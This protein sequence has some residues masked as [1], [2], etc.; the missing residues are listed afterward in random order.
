MKV[1][2]N[3]KTLWTILTGG[4]LS[5]GA[6]PNIVIVVIR[7]DPSFTK[8]IR[9]SNRTIHE[10][11]LDRSYYLRN[12]KEREKISDENRSIRYLDGQSVFG[13]PTSK[14]ILRQWRAT[15]RHPRV[16]RQLERNDPRTAVGRNHPADYSNK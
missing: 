5:I 7:F 16:L 12:C 2:K 4:E 14:T 8:S 3:R 11:I 10:R 6:P 13:H 9:I 1:L 15:L